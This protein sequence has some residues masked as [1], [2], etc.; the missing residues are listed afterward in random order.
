MRQD[1][2]QNDT[3]GACAEL[4][5]LSSTIQEFYIHLHAA[6]FYFYFWM[7]G[8]FENKNIASRNNDFTM[9]KKNL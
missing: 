2:Q 6:N 3:I 7:V 9:T 4:I 5:I 1:E 8:G